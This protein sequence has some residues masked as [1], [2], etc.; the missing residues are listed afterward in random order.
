MSEDKW[1]ALVVAEI[2]H[3]VPGEDAFY[4]NDNILTIGSNG[5]EKGITVGFHV[6]MFPDLSFFIDDTDIHF[7]CVQ[8]D[9]AVVL[10]LI[11]VESHGLPPLL[12]LFGLSQF[13][14]YHVLGEALNSIKA[15]PVIVKSDYLFRFEIVCMQNTFS[16]AEQV[17][18]FLHN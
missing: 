5:F 6:A 17:D 8:I 7:S 16:F 11:I 9:S 14:I 18:C 13:Q 10:V 1:N 4:S 3:P 15:V 2:C 12:I